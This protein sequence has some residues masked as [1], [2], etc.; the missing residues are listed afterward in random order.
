MI[1]PSVGGDRPDLETNIIQRK[2]LRCTAGLRHQGLIKIP[3]NVW[4]VE[5]F[6]P[7]KLGCAPDGKIYSGKYA[8]LKC[9]GAK[10]SDWP[11]CNKPSS[12]TNQVETGHLI[13]D[14]LKL[15]ICRAGHLHLMQ[16][17]P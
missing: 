13:K 15:V 8:G 14:I 5:S 17:S 1:Y 16:L 7:W 4:V 3:E 12:Q 9:Q 11:S 2:P 10:A 6:I